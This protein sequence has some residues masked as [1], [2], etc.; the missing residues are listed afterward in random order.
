[1][2]V[3]ILSVMFGVASVVEGAVQHKMKRDRIERER[4]KA[5]KRRCHCRLEPCEEGSGK[6][7]NY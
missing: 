7:Y 4:I 5:Y 6:F 1:M 3:A 2:S